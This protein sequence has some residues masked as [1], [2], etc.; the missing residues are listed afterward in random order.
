MNSSPEQ[1]TLLK[2]LFLSF[3]LVLYI[4]G[5]FALPGF[6]FPT[7]KIL[8]EKYYLIKNPVRLTKIYDTIGVKYFRDLLLMFFWGTP[9]NRKKYF[10]G[11]RKGLSNF[12][13]QSKQ[14]EFG[15]LA[16]LLTV[17]LLT[18]PLLFKGFSS[19]VLTTTV[20]NIF[21]NLYPIILQRYHRIRIDGLIEKGLRI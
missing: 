18:I 13:C 1:F 10:D 21:G 8:N 17:Q 16:A 3:L 14:S 4:T 15:H 5:I 19:M 20:I 7:S 6:A 11:T 2:T 12:V 9:G